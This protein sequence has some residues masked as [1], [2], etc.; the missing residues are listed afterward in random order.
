MKDDYNDFINRLRNEFKGEAASGDYTAWFRAMDSKGYPLPTNRQ[1]REFTNAPFQCHGLELYNNRIRY[2]YTADY[3]YAL[4]T[5][6]FIDQMVE[7]L[8]DKK[9]LEVMS[10]TGYFGSLLKDRG[11]DI[12]C[13]DDDSWDRYKRHKRFTEI[14]VMDAVEAVNKY[15]DQV[16]VVIMSWPPYDDPIAANVARCCYKHNLPI[17]FIGE[18]QGGCTADNDFFEFIDDYFIIDFDFDKNFMS[19]CFIHDNCILLTPKKH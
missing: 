11:I 10:G 17:I 1:I 13:T 7:Y 16:D 15:A 6:E 2:V 9:V 8:K 19:F 5:K 14:E 12:V 3:S 4:L 18:P